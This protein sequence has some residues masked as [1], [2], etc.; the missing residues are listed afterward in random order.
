MATDIFKNLFKYET[1][2]TPE[3]YEDI[4]D[5]IEKVRE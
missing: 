1:N 4:S 5:L 3:N 2:Q